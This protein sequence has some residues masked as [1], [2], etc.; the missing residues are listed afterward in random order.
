MKPKVGMA[1]RF[2]S[3]DLF[4]SNVFFNTEYD[5]IEKML[6]FQMSCQWNG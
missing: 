6:R 2:V 3:L 5:G 4:N 1:D